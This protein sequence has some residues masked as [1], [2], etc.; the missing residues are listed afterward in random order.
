MSENHYGENMIDAGYH[1][2]RDAEMAEGQNPQIPPLNV[3]NM[4]PGN[5]NFSAPMSGHL[6]NQVPMGYHGT[7]LS[8][9]NNPLAIDRAQ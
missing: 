5:P 4:Y 7:N 1:M 9:H 8:I 6:N 3:N 2:N